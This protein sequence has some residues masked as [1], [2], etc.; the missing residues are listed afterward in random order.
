MPEGDPM[1]RYEG[2]VAVV[3]GGNSGIG[4]ATAKAFAREGAAVVISGRDE[5][6]LRAAEAEIGGGA[7]AVRADASKL[8]D[9][10]ALMEKV[11]AKH[12]RIDA[13]FVN[14]GV[15]RFLPFD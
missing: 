3:T 8:A 10:D 2:K 5:K 9:L 4:L 7:T 15:G 1:K 13:L 14:A 6:T 12:G 11:K